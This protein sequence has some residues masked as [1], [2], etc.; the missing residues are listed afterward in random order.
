MKVSL[1]ETFERLMLS[2][3]ANI[4]AAIQ[5]PYYP[6]FAVNN[7]YGLKTI[8]DTIYTFM[9]ASSDLVSTNEDSLLTSTSK[10]TICPK[11]VR[12]KSLTVR[13]P[14]VPLRKATAIA[15]LP[16]PCAVR[17]SKNPTTPL[18]ITGSTTFVIPTMTRP[19]P[20]ILSSISTK[21]ALRKL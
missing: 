4:T 8:N 14:T 18:A 2:G 13:S 1:R 6:E 17:S 9:K 5:A 20:T 16:Q 15:L 7:T 11:A 10:L 21:Q 3:W 12:T 19:L